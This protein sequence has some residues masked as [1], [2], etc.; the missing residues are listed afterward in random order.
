MS[1][2]PHGADLADLA[3][4]PLMESTVSWQGSI[5]TQQA[6]VNS[7]ADGQ[8]ALVTQGMTTPVVNVGGGSQPLWKNIRLGDGL[9]LAF[10]SPLPPPGPNGQPG[11][12]MNV[13]VT[14]MTIYPSGP[15]QSEYAQ[16]TTSAVVAL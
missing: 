2:W 6:Q 14:G 1:Q 5:V 8:V 16:L 11:L 10:T 13:R 4:Y 3:S 7:F 12:Q 15:Q 9:Q